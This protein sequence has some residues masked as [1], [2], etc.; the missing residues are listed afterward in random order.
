MVGSLIYSLLRAVLEVLVTSRADQAKLQAEVLVLRHHVQ[1]LDTHGHREGLLDKA[2]AGLWSR[3]SRAHP[4]SVAV[5]GAR[6][7]KA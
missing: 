7:Q 1:V 5:A 3:A 4:L 6:M 2:A